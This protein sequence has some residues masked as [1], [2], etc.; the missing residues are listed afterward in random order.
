M[1]YTVTLNPSLDRTLHYTHL[2]LGAVNRATS[3]RTDLSGKGV[4]VSAALRSLGLTS[5][6]CACVGGATGR[7]LAEGLRDQGYDTALVNVTG[8][9]RSNVTVID[10]ATGVATKLNE[11]GP[12]MSP[13]ALAEMEQLL[14]SRVAPGDWY[15]FSGSLPP[16][17]PVDTYA[18]LIAVLHKRGALTALDTSGE[19]LAW[20]CRAG[21]DLVKPNEYEA[22]ELLPSDAT[23]DWVQ[24]VAAI[25][26]L[27][28]QRVLL[29]RGAAG[30]LW[31]DA[32]GVWAGAA[33]AIHEVNNVGAG[34]AALGGAVYAL[35]AGKASPEC[36]RWAL[37]LGSA[38]AATDGTAMPER[39]TILH[40]LDKIAV[41]RLA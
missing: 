34:D 28:P 29:T 35:H 25:R 24:R 26:A 22:A 41:R 16:G 1:I 30:A 37:A 14:L 19:A 21:P 10:D 9:T 12:A 33:P 5:T 31:A 36:L 20:G 32:E 13:A 11:P 6:I 17:A 18:R 3:A 38:K 8:E 40:M 7:A 27:G 4:N 2:V 39:E 23:Q 15:V